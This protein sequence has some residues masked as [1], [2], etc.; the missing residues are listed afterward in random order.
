MSIYGTY[1]Q[2]QLDAQYNLRARHPDHAAHFE[3]WGRA[4]AEAR[5]ALDCHP[6]LRFG[7]AEAQSLDL[8]LPSAARTPAPVVAFIHGGY[9]QAM[10]KADFGFVAPPFVEAGIAFASL[11]YTLAPAA[12]MHEIVAEIRT[13]LAWLP[14]NGGGFGLD[15]SRLYVCGHSAGGHLTAMALTTDWPALG[16]DLPG[17][18]IRGGCAISG[19]YDLEPIRLSYLNQALGM[20]PED[21]RAASPVQAAA[22]R[23]PL[24]LSVGGEETEEFHRQ[25]EAL[26]RAWGGGGMLERIDMP[27]RDHF[28]IMDALAD[29]ES[30][31]FQRTCRLV[32]DDAR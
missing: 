11:N 29:A 13:A 17:D 8:Y 18:L 5:Q 26:F 30:A 12:S 16:P 28:T 25:Q 1:D 10:D 23:V 24:L 19:L 2:E 3:R 32:R 4:S 15:P 31:L 14:R 6:D 20:G 22:P 9:W 7:S 21:A 27:G